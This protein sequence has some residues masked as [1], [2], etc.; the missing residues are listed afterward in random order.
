V[1]LEDE[2]AEALAEEEMLEVASSTVL[3]P[4]FVARQAV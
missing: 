3:L 2:V 1:R 4:Q